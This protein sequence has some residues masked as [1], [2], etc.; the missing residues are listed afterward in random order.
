MKRAGYYVEGKF[1]ADR[2]HQARAHAAHLSATYGRGI[3]LM[4]RDPGAAEAVLVLT[5][6]NYT[7]RAA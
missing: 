4:R 2:F 1:F 5:C 3:D 6:I 7:R